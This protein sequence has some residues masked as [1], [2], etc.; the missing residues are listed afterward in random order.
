MISIWLPIISRSCN[1][2][3]IQKLL[4]QRTEIVNKTDKI[5]S[6]LANQEVLMAQLSKLLNNLQ[7]QF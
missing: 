1:S 6:R 4:T 3:M 7:F 2:M 5:E